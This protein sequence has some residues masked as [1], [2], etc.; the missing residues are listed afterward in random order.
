MEW[1]TIWWKAVLTLTAI[2]VLLA[3]C[4][5]TGKLSTA[6][7]ERVLAAAGFQVKFADTPEK[8]ELL[9]S[10]PQRKIFVKE[11]DGKDHYVYADATSCKCVYVGDEKAYQRAQQ[12]A[13]QREM[14]KEDIEAAEMYRDTPMNWGAWGPWRPWY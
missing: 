8:M 1:K 2:G 10:L 14:D 4:A 9:K 6:D 12:L 3:G 7:Q 13:A 11:K 5:T